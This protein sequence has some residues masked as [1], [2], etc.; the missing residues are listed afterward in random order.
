MSKVND[1]QPLFGKSRIRAASFRKLTTRA[2]T[3]QIIK[4]K[5]KFFPKALTSQ[6]LFS[7]NAT[8]FF[9][10]KPEGHL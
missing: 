6:K 5:Q 7:E 10:A 3:E 2:L 9:F 1:S 4:W 8:K